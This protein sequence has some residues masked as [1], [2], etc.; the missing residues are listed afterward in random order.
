LKISEVKRIKYQ[1]M[2]VV[3]TG[4]GSKERSLLKIVRFSGS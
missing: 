4:G 3:S 1:H 2:R